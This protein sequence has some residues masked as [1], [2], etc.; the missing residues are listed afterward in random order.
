MGEIAENK[1]LDNLVFRQIEKLERQSFR[2]GVQTRYTNDATNGHSANDGNDEH[3]DNDEEVFYLYIEFPRFDH[4][5]VFTDQEYPAPPISTVPISPTADLRTRPAPEVTPGPG[6]AANADAF[7]DETA[8]RLIRIYDPEVAIRDNP[9]E[10]KHRRIVRSHRTG[11]MDRDL[12]PNAKIRDELNTIMAYGPQHDLTPEEKDLVWKFRH[13][14]TR[15]KRALT[16]LVKS[17]AWNDQAEVRI[18]I[19][20]LPKWTQIDVDDALELLGPTFDNP[21]VRAY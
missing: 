21:S 2:K 18:A 10:N 13:H 15:D 7:G 12:K 9:A 5:I 8:G 3:G 17:V 20:I 11:V 4:P 14:L 1:W 6:I 19:Q 16:K